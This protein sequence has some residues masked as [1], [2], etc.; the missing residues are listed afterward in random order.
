MKFEYDNYELA[1]Y[2]DTEDLGSNEFMNI[3]QS[4]AGM[5]FNI[6]Q[7]Y[8]VE[9]VDDGYGGKIYHIIRK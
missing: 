8:K 6:G 4:Q 9:E 2:E 3:W 1:I 7:N 5:C